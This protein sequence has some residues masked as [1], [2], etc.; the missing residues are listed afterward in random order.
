MKSFHMENRLKRG[1]SMSK[2]PIPLSKNTNKQQVVNV[3]TNA[4]QAPV[5]NKR[6]TMDEGKSN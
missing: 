4:S 2:R 1:N 3:I 5:M 6:Y